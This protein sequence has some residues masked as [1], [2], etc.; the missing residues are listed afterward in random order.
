MDDEE[1]ART[2]FQVCALRMWTTA[3][4]V[5]CMCVL[6]WCVRAC[7]IPLWRNDEGG[8][9]DAEAAR[10]KPLHLNR[11]RRTQKQVLALQVLL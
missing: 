8:M 10:P 1:I 7:E 6:R 2:T 9:I 5:R 3:M 4:P 11:R